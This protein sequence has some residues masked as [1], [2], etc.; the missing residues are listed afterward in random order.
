MLTLCYT[1]V[2]ILFIIVTIQRFEIAAL[3]RRL[4]VV[5]FSVALLIDRLKRKLGDF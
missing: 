4:G 2:F 3:K 1:G 5:D